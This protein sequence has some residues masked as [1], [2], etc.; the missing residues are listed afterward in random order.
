MALFPILICNKSKHKR[1]RE[2]IRTLTTPPGL[3]NHIERVHVQCSFKAKL[4]MGNASVT[5]ANSVW[6]CILAFY[7][8]KR[9]NPHVPVHTAALPHGGNDSDESPWIRLSLQ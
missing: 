7:I 3:W 5:R 8:H 9:L 6:K 4:W 1:M 2:D